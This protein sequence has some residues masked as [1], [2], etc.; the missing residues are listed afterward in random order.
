MKFDSKVPTSEPNHEV[1]PK[2]ECSGKVLSRGALFPR[3]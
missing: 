1:T 3:Y 2:I